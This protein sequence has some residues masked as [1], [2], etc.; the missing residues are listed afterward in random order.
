MTL[1]IQQWSDWT[2]P[3]RGRFTDWRLFVEVVGKAPKDP[4]VYFLAVPS[5]QEPMRPRKLCRF[6]NED[7]HGLLDIGEAAN[8]QRRLQ[9]LYKC[10]TNRGAPGHMAGWRLGSMGLIDRLGCKADQ[11]LVSWFK[12]ES[13]DEAYHWEGR[14]L[15]VYFSI[16]GELP[17]L[18]YKFNWSEFSK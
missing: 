10:A 3:N 9:V 18:N 15:N 14:M 4:G 6:L 12:L 11:L 7:P 16:F 2:F 13:K 17:P 1:T 8:L 5:V